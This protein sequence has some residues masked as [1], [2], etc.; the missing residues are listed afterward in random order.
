MLGVSGSSGESRGAGSILVIAMPS[1][2]VRDTSG[3]TVFSSLKCMPVGVRTTSVAASSTTS[4]S[5]RITV[6][7]VPPVQHAQTVLLALL[8]ILNSPL[9]LITL[10]VFLLER[11]F[12]INF[13]LLNKF[14]IFTELKN[15]HLLRFFV[16]PLLLDCLNT[17]S[18]FDS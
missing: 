14:V 17:N 10:F 18:L 6:L 9:L 1:A 11:I 8:A 16:I 5:I 15:N 4:V 13:L 2:S 7:R 3:R 12:F